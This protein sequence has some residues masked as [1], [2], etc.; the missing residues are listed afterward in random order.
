MTA[1]RLAS[2]MTAALAATTTDTRTAPAMTVTTSAPAVT[3][4]AALATRAA[5][6]ATTLALRHLRSVIVATDP[7]PDAHVTVRLLCAA[8]TAL[9]HAAQTASTDTSPAPAK[10]PPPLLP[11]SQQPRALQHQ[12][13]Q[14]SQAHPP[15]RNPLANATT[16]ARHGANAKTHATAIEAIGRASMIAGM[17]RGMAG[18]IVDARGETDSMTLI[19]MFLVEE[20]LRRKTGVRR[21]VE[22]GRGRGIVVEE[23]T[24]GGV[25]ETGVGGVEARL[26]YYVREERNC[27][28][29]VM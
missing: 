15:N 22:V 19:D 25:A 16:P 27:R 18:G 28:D 8:A 23:E 5:N 4:A 13:P 10:S 24:G 7:V 20:E 6:P 2:K 1:V 3:T 29:I 11:P 9:A 26:Y 21:G 12:Q 14:S 17:E